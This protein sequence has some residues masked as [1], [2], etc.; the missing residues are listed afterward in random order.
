M[1]CPGHCLMFGHRLRS[2]RELPLRYA[3]FGVLHRNELSGALSGL[4]RVRRFQQDDAHIFCA[5]DQIESEISGVLDL[6]QYSYGVFGFHFDLQLSTRPAKFLGEIK[7][8]D[9]AEASLAKCLTIFCKKIGQKWTINAADGA[10]YGPKIDIQLTDALKRKHQCATIQLDFQ[11]P[12]RFD[13]KFKNSAG[14]M[15]HP[16]MIHR[17]IL[18]STERMF[19]VLLEHLAGKWPFWL[20][21]RQIIVVSCYEESAEYSKEVGKILHEAGYYV[22]V[23]VSNHHIKKKIKD[24]QLAQWN[25]ILVIGNEEVAHRSVNVRQRHDPNKLEEMPLQA[26]LEMAQKLEASHQ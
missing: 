15:E 25:F 4:T 6:L 12:R 2:Y 20:S 11:L 23:D 14:E 22:E 7:M 8:W 13:L 1:N 26:F 5:S 3:D 18:G 21:P 19:A 17:A 9:E 10:F 16:V 24:A